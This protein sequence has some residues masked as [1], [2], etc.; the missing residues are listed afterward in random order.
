MRAAP[1]VGIRPMER[2]VRTG[3]TSEQAGKLGFV[4][5]AAV[6]GGGAGLIFHSLAAGVVGAAVTGGL[7]L[8]YVSPIIGPSS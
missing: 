4:L 6:A 5:M 3:A 1:R 2:D 7:A 8:V